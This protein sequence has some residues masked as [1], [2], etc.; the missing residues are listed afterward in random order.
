MAI[1]V[2]GIAIC[3]LIGQSLSF[4]DFSNNWEGTTLK[5]SQFTNIDLVIRKHLIL[6]VVPLFGTGQ[7]KIYRFLGQVACNHS[8]ITESYVCFYEIFYLPFIFHFVL[9]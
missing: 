8:I 3:F 6:K 7:W 9:C 2:T 4:E 1:V 5:F